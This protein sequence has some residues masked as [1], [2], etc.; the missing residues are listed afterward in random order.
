MVDDFDARYA[1]AIPEWMKNDIGNWVKGLQ[2]EDGF[3]YH[4][5]WGKE[6]GLSRRSRDFNW[7]LGILKS[8]GKEKKY[9]TILDKKDEGEKGETLIPDHLSSKEKFLKYLEDGNIAENS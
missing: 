3:F 4:P 1:K 9:P 8:L 6:I 7:C 2:N 5:Q